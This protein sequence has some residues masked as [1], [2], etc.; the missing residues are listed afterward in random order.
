MRPV[1]E[2]IGALFGMPVSEG[3]SRPFRL[4]VLLVIVVAL[5]ASAGLVIAL[6]M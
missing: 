1:I 5:F 6:Q 2:A 4:T 3:K